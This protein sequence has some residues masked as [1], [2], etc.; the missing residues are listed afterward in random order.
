MPRSIR[1]PSKFRHVNVIGKVLRLPSV[2]GIA[3]WAGTVKWCSGGSRT[4]LLSLISLPV[5]NLYDENWSSVRH[6]LERGDLVTDTEVYA[7]WQ[8]AAM[9]LYKD[10][11]LPHVNHSV[12]S[13]AIDTL[14]ASIEGM[15]ISIASKEVAGV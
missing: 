13:V 14:V 10:L 9:A 15:G 12:E 3:W 5:G 11:A 6:W 1:Y 8:D 2:K 4:Q 7:C